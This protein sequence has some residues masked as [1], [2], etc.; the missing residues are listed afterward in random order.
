M[1]PGFLGLLA[2]RLQHGLAAERG[3]LHRV[4]ARA[5]EQAVLDA[6]VHLGDK[7]VDAFGHE[8]LARQERIAREERTAHRPAL[9]ATADLADHVRRELTHFVHRRVGRVAFQH[10]R[11]QRLDALE[12]L[13]RGGIVD[14]RKVADQHGEFVSLFLLI[15]G[16]E[17]RAIVVESAAGILAVRVVERAIVNVGGEPVLRAQ[18]VGE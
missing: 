17:R 5:I 10:L 12:R 11:G 2:A 4:A 18:F 9:A 16:A 7:F 8:I 1:P 6:L 15:T 14:R 3:D 13:L